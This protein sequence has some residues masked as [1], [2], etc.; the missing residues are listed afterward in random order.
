[1]GNREVFHSH[2]GKSLGSCRGAG[3]PAGA[4]F[5][6]HKLEVPRTNGSRS[7]GTNP[8]V[9]DLERRRNS[10]NSHHGE[11]LKVLLHPLRIAIVVSE[12][13][14]DPPPSER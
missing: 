9:V 1:M 6:C 4:R 7:N 8:H 13:A 14:F 11:W 10:C 3:S 12:G 5:C 2:G